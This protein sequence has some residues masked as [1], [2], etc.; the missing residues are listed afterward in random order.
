MLSV[1][2]KGGTLHSW[3]V[4]LTEPG[5]AP[6]FHRAPGFKNASRAVTIFGGAG[7]PERFARRHRPCT[8]T[9]RC[10]QL[11]HKQTVARALPMTPMT[12]VCHGSADD[13]KDIL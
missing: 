7:G 3:V 9:H 2:V 10:R 12:L 8:S 4:F 11:R 13:M 5:G 1:E 6:P